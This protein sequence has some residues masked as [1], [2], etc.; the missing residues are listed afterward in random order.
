MDL[1]PL[2]TTFAAPPTPDDDVLTVT[3]GHLAGKSIDE[4]CILDIRQ[5]FG[6]HFLDIIAEGFLIPADTEGPSPLF[7]QGPQPLHGV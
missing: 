1:F 2:N 3:P 6:I 7:P 4:V 5:H